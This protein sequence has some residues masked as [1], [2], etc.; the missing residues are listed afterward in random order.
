MPMPVMVTRPSRAS[1]LRA[2]DVKRG[3]A[4]ERLADG[5]LEVV[6]ALRRFDRL[7]VIVDSGH[8]G[9]L[10]GDELGPVARVLPLG[11]RRRPG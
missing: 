10:A 1:T 6:Q 4:F 11:G 5:L 8:A 3:V 9:H 2:A 7:D